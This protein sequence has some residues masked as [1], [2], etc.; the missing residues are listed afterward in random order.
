MFVEVLAQYGDLSKDV[1]KDIGW[2]LVHSLNEEICGLIVNSNAINLLIA[3]VDYQEK[4]I[5]L[6]NV[7]L[8][9]L[10]DFLDHEPKAVEL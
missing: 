2:S 8:I 3:L 1:V 5:N 10:R 4:D 6:L 7:L 9:I